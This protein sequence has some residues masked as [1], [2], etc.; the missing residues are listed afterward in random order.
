[1]EKRGARRIYKLGL[2]DNNASLEDDYVDGKMIYGRLWCNIENKILY[3]GKFKS[4][5]LYLKK[6]YNKKISKDNIYPNNNH[7]LR[8]LS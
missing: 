2:G 4:K 7:C 6:I 5:H 3:R 8:I 1:M